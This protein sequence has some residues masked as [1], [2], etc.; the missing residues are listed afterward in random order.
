MEQV[1][2]GGYAD[3]LAVGDTEYNLL[4]GGKAWTGTSYHVTSTVSTAGVIKNLR[5]KL[6]GSPAVGKSY[7]FTLMV[8]GAPTALTIHIHDTD[9]SGADTVNE[10]DVVA[11]NTVSLRC[12]PTGTPDARTATWTSM[13]EGATAN[14]SLILGTVGTYELA[15]RY[16]NPMGYSVVNTPENEARQV[17]P[18]AGTIKDLYIVLN[19][20][21]GAGG[22]AYR[23]TLRLNGAT[24]AQSLIVT[25]TEPDKTGNDVA[26]NLVVVAGDVLT[27]M[28]EPL[29][30]PTANPYAAFGM[31]FVAD[32]DGESIVLAGTYDN[33]SNSATEYN[34]LQAG[35]GNTWDIEGN[36]P[37]LG[38]EC[39]LKKLYVLLSGSPGVG[40]SYDF[41]VRVAG[42]SS[43]V[44]VHIHDNDTT[45]NSGA[46]DDT[47]ADDE[48]VGLMVVPLSSPTVR[49]AYW[50]LVCFIAPPVAPTVT[51]QA[52]SSIEDT[53]ATGN[54]NITDV[55]SENCDIRG[56]VWDLA[57]QGA[58]GNVAPGASGYANDVAETD[59]F[60]T[61]AFTRSL[62]GLPTGDI[63][64]AR[65]YAHNSAGYA[66][67][68][69]VSFLTKPAAPA[70][71]DATDGDHTD[72]VVITWTKSTGATGYKVYEG[73]NL[74]DTL[75]DVATYDDEAAAAPTITA[76]T[77]AATDGL[78]AYVTLSLS[79][80]SANNGASRT[81]KVIALNATGDSDASGT[82]AGYRGV[83]SLTYQWQISAADSDADY[84]NISGATTEPY[85]HPV[86]HSDGRYYQCVENATG[87]SEQTS[88]ADRG[89][90]KPLEV[91]DGDLIGIGIIRKS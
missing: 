27:M 31:T 51:T 7:D 55:G 6:G 68:D 53:T 35:Y 29:N 90:R 88:S 85:N 73:E 1:M 89:W 47:V 11:G 43:D 50:G 66:Y 60:G 26:H 61:G 41:T 76:G 39:T 10:I 20:D 87:A 62:T 83:G 32:T 18:T 28:V 79:G 48:Y 80:E 46:L 3:N 33:L 19:A 45:G 77:G 91:A 12:V 36:R 56:I 2:F 15:T 16:G 23:F 13:F 4:V 40:N 17:C 69:E 44:T 70:N 58:P 65:A 49:D 9:T 81:Y 24:V 84:S 37:D 74:L 82:N 22:D 25:I 14:E 72:K 34:Y 8:D 52:A 75:G 86:A 78:T 5:V 63:I 71:V 59:S 38:Q 30:S 57:S 42:A 21:P 54:G 64:Y 67:G